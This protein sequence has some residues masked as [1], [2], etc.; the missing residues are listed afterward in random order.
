MRGDSETTK[1][2]QWV[3]LSSDGQHRLLSNKLKGRWLH[4]LH[5]PT[6]SPSHTTIPDPSSRSGQASKGRGFC[7]RQDEPQP[8]VS[9]CVTLD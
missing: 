3:S 8:R 6:L 1:A 9:G 2:T 5:P 4:P 7:L